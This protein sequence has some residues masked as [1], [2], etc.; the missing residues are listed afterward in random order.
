MID[1]A[2][3]LLYIDDDLDDL[4]IFGESICRL[5]PE[6]TVLKAQSAD[7]G[8]EILHR[9]EKENKPLPCLIVLDM[10]MPRK[11][12]R[13]T[14]NEIRRHQQWEDIPVVVFTTSANN[15]DIEFC[16]SYGTSCI[17]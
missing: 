3:T 17:T 6:I 13:Q 4:M 9:M 1:E 2:T 11:D 16:S 8:I 5:Y 12:G 15:A 10:N 7:E 14:L